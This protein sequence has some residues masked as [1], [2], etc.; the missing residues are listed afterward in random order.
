[1]NSKNTN[2]IVGPPGTGK[3]T[4]LLEVVEGVLARGIKPNKIG[5]ISF[6]KK[7]AE[8]GKSRASEKFGIA[9]EDLPHFRTLHSM[10]FKYLGMRRDQMVGWPHIRELGR[11]LGIDFKGR[12]EI[13]ED[14][15]YGMNSADRMLF[16]EG[17]A[18]NIKRP[19]KDVWN[20]A[21][22]DEIDWWELDRFAKALESFKRSRSL[23]DFTDLLERF[24]LSQVSTL[25]QLDVLIIDE[26]QDLSLL[27]W[28][29]VELI[30]TNAKE[31]YV[32]GDDDQAIYKWSGAD[33]SKF[34]NLPGRARVLD[35]SYRIPSTVHTLADS[36]SNRISQRRPKIWA[37]RL[38]IGSVNWFGNIEEVDLSKGT[39]LL[40]ARNG[41]MLDELEDWCMSQGFSFNSVN[42]DPLKSP[43]LS[44]VRVWENLRK[45]NEESAERVLET[46]KYIPA[47]WTSTVL[48]KKLKADENDRMYSM[49]ELVR[50]GLRTQDVWYT[51]LAKISDKER[52][53]F[54]AALRRKESLLKEP[55]IKISTIHASKGGQADHVLLVTDMS[56]R[57][58]NNMQTNY[59]DE[60]RVWYVA[61]TRCRQ[62]LNLVMPRT[63]LNFDF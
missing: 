57:C 12:G 22:E 41:Y 3:T 52:E 39:W 33:V 46:L 9:P 40:L 51:A 15:V 48:M 29:A 28:D 38:E 63:N 19:L 30:S 53:F 56:Y 49:P 45:G 20:E 61:A 26:A 37:P 25:P 44:A 14:D 2:I 5:F 18:R 36:V 43:A 55:R 54:R 59:D 35:I 21:F 13:A 7:A 58:H 24:C 60:V 27:Q 16:L 42:R 8:E 11:M 62:S 31:V 6:T 4:S 50:L 32:A 10:A 47:H 34:I 1:M 17:L 23:S